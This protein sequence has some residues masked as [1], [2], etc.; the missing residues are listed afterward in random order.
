MYFDPINEPP[1]QNSVRFGP[2]KNIAAIHGHCPLGASTPPTIRPVVNSCWPQ[3]SGSTMFVR[4][5]SMPLSGD[6][7]IG[8]RGLGVLCSTGRW[9]TSTKDCWVVWIVGLVVGRNVSFTGF[10]VVKMVD[11]S[12]G[13]QT[14]GTNKLLKQSDSRRLPKSKRRAGQLLRSSHL[15]LLP[16]GVLQRFS[17][18]LPLASFISAKN[19]REKLSKLRNI[20]FNFHSIFKTKG[21]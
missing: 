4:L 9:G 13:Q 18:S 11:C 21:R 3:Y 20:I 7:I 12:I 16:S 14:P 17:P 6:S 5:P 2:C 19:K 15:P 10:C 1:H 8:G